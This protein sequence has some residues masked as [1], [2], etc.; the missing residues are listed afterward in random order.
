[1]WKRVLPWRQRQP[2]RTDWAEDDPAAGII[3]A[4]LNGGSIVA[5]AGF[6]YGYVIG[7][8]ASSMQKSD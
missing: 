3:A 8:G 2:R 7:V 5:V 1:M 4:K 6:V